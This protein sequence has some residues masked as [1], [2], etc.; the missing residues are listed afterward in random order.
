MAPQW[1]KAFQAD[2]DTKRRILGSA[3]GRAG[4]V[5]NKEIEASM[6]LTLLDPVGG[7]VGMLP[8]L[9]LGRRRSGAVSD[10]MLDQLIATRVEGRLFVPSE[11]RHI[12]D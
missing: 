8:S 7:S 12:R 11:R 6:L 2:V 9:E 4:T 1:V 5:A 10:R 3:P